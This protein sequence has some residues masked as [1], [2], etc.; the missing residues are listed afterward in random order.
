MTGPRNEKAPRTAATA[1]RARNVASRKSTR[2]YSA[3]KLADKSADART[4][5]ARRH[6]A[7]PLRR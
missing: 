3:K 6:R 5:L 4:W 1:R 2:S 7:H